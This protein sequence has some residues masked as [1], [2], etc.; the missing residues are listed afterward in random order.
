[1]TPAELLD[2]RKVVK[3]VQVYVDEKVKDYIVDVVFATRDPRASTG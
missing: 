1:M 2:A 3:Q